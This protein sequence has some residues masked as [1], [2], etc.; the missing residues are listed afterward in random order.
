MPLNIEIAQTIMQIPR[1]TVPEMA[2]HIIAATA[3][4]LN[5]PLVSCDSRI[6]SLN[7]QIIW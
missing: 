4:Y 3:F 2:D 6:Q 5:L 1:V 7:M